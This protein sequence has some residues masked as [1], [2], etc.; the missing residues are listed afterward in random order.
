[1]ISHEYYTSNIY[2]IELNYLAHIEVSIT[3]DG[4]KSFFINSIAVP[5]R[6][7][8]TCNKKFEDIEEAKEEAAKKIL[9]FYNIDSNRIDIK[10]MLEKK[11]S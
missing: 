11:N 5:S 7:P 6:E 10:I 3:E 4:E 2:P 9:Q 1:M 8:I